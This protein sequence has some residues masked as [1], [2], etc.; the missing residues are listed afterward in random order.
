MLPELDSYLIVFISGWPWLDH[1]S[2]YPIWRMNESPF[3][4]IFYSF[5]C[6]LRADSTSHSPISLMVID[7]TILRP[8]SSTLDGEFPVRMDLFLFIFILS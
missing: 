6:G 1:P 2:P 3:I 7:V 5:C 8:L 4:Q